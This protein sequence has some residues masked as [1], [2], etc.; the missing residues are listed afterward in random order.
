MPA[1]TLHRDS[2]SFFEVI[3]VAKNNQNVSCPPTNNIYFYQPKQSSILILSNYD[4]FID[5]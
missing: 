1:M 5:S 3:D 2:T 4:Y